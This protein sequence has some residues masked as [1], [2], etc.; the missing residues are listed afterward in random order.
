VHRDTGSTRVSGATALAAVTPRSSHRLRLAALG[1]VALLALVIAALA[2]RWTSWFGNPHI[3]SQTELNPQ[4]LTS[5][6]TDDPVVGGAMS[7]DGKYLQYADLE[8]I[9]LRIMSSGETETLP[10]PP[11]FCFR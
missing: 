10:T 5:S 4:Q 8:G 11:G 6:S 2:G 1:V 3:Y 7:P 9:H